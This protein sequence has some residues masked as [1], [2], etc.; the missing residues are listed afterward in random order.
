[1]STIVDPKVQEEN[2]SDYTEKTS[3]LWDQLMGVEMQLVDQLEVNV[4]SPYKS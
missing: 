1:M 4:A 2:I 3:V